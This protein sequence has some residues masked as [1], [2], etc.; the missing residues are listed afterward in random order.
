MLCVTIDTMSNTS[1]MKEIVDL[2]CQD[3]VGFE[4]P[5]IEL[6]KFLFRTLPDQSLTFDN[7]IQIFFH[8]AYEN[9]Q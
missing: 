4:D 6:G 1:I 8:Y 7:N 3:N 9:C 2:V 5:F